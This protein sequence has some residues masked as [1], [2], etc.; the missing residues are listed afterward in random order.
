MRLIH[1]LATSKKHIPMKNTIFVLIA[2]TL[3]CCKGKSKSEFSLIGTTNGIDNGTLVYL[4]NILENKLIDSTKVENNSFCF[5]TKLPKTPLEVAL[6]TKDESHWRSLWLENNPM[7]FDGKNTDFEN[8][9]VAGSKTEDLSQRLYNNI[10]TLPRSKMRNLEKEFV[11]NNP[12]SIISASLLSFYSTTWG[13]DKTKE[14]FNPFSLENKRSKY[15]KMIAKYIE[16]N[17]VPKIGEQFVDFEMV[18]KNGITKKLSDLKGKT[19]LLEFWASWCHGCRQENPHLVKTYQKFN[20]K[21]FEIFAV[22]Q[23]D[24]KENWLKAIKKDKLNWEHVSDLKG[25]R[26]EASLIYGI[27]KIPDNFL[28]DENGVIIGRDLHGENLEKKLEEIMPVA[29]TRSYNIVGL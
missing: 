13:K 29:K 8:A 19:V 16:L 1:L 12:N 3:I 26:N 9:I 23:D 20:S 22:S 18:D 14:L 21:G 5:Q 4:Y 17:K 2:L 6:Y 24:N 25:S 7:T 28:I 10:D 27:N 11:Q 15:G